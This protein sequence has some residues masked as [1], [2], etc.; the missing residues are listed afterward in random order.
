MILEGIHYRYTLGRT[1]GGGFERIGDL[2]PVFIE[3]GLTT[4]QE[5]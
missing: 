1:V 2:V 4:L 3:H 5:G